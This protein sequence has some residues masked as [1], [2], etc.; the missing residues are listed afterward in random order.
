MPSRMDRYYGSEEDTKKR[1]NRNQD[2]YKTIYDE[3]EYT[4]VEGISI[5]E[6]NE[7][8]DI[9]KIRELIGT[10][11][12]TKKRVIEAKN[13]EF[14]PVVEDYEEKNYDIRDI[15]DKAKSERPEKEAG[16]T[17]YDILKGISLN[18]NCK[19]PQSLSDEDLK[20]MIETIT[21]NS[22]INQTGDLLDDLKTIHD[23]DMQTLVEEQ[24]EL[25]KTG[26]INDIDKS[27]YTS[28]LGF[29]TDDFENLKEIKD[30]IKKNN[31]LTKALLFVLLVILL[32]GI[33]FFI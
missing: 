31:F 24:M 33:L 25:G 26:N 8:I 9:N 18:D 2:L 22:K 13:E 32:V 1:T 16:N 5:I 12:E 4:N 15:L 28:S 14:N 23:C 27:F 3:V 10:T 17:Q 29:T 11:N 21:N 19:V 30:D 7:K 6:K 20:K